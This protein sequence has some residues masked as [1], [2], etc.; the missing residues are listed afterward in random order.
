MS[1]DLLNLKRGVSYV[2]DAFMDR[3]ERQKQRA[4]LR[5]MY[6]LRLIFLINGFAGTRSLV[7]VLVYD[8]ARNACGL[9]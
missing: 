6:V 1:A 2:E 4:S 5:P 8:S 3:G 9:K 7:R